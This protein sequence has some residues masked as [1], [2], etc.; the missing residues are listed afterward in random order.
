MKLKECPKYR[1]RL[2]LSVDLVGSTASKTLASYKAQRLYPEWVEAFKLFFTRFPQIL[3]THY[4]DKKG[5]L[6]EHKHLENGMPKVWKTVGDEILFSVR[7]T[8][9]RHVSCCMSAFMSAL[10]QFGNELAE[11]YPTL[12]VKGAAWIATFPVRNLTIALG[13]A[14]V[15]IQD[16]LPIEETE[17]N[18]DENPLQFD[19]LGVDIDTGFRVA[20]KASTEYLAVTADLAYMLAE[21]AL[22]NMMSC[23]FIYHGRQELKGVMGGKPYPIVSLYCERDHRRRNLSAR[24]ELLIGTKGVSAVALRDYLYSYLEFERLEIT[25]LPKEPDEATGVPVSYEE[26]LQN[27]QVKQTENER[28][29]NDISESESEVHAQ[30]DDK[31]SPLISLFVDALLK[32]A[33]ISTAAKKDAAKE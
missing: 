2:Y 7:A 24:E 1:V 8:S 25:S 16:E 10:A 30:G 11:A 27:W 26:Y 22:H 31:I 4:N 9:L 28:R 33:A 6:P 3:S 12:D 23:Q 19:F 29:D 13:K 20:K 21:S 14:T 17:I 15:E 5:S 32:N 18:A